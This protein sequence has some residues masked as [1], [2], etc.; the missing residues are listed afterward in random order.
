MAIGDAPA[1]LAVLL[2][3]VADGD[4]IQGFDGWI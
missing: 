1:L 2:K 4:E 3:G